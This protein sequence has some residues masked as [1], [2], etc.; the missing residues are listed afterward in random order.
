MKK[1]LIAV[2]LVMGCATTTAIAETF[3]E[4]PLTIIVPYAAGGSSD[5]V[6]RAAGKHIAEATG[7][8]VV[9]ENRP[10]GAT[11]IGAQ[12]L[13]SKP[14]DG[15]TT[16]LVAASFVINPHLL[17]LPYDPDTSFR[18][19]TLVASNPHVLVVN[20]SVPANSLSEFVE[21][22]KS[23]NGGASFSSF[24]NGSSGH[25]G[26]EMLNQMAD[27]NM[28]HVPYKGAAPATMAV[29]SGE[30]DATLADI[31]V[32][33]PHLKSG[34]GKIKA[35][36]ITGD[37]RAATLPD[38]PTFKE[39]GMP[40][41]NSR[42]WLGLW[43]RAE[44]PDDKVRRLNQLF[45]DALKSEEMQALLAQQGFEAGS[46]T[47]EAFAEFAKEESKRYKAAIEKANIRIE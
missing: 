39:S 10:G 11:V 37:K 30:V 40:E 38:V 26:F 8:S 9:V 4:R 3:P 32:V 42:T 20:S 15:Y 23:K 28:L 19:V 7:Q 43:T 25:I 16:M 29:L 35:I 27:I 18:P 13:L 44:V 41:Y 45:N 47:P 34:E 46:T 21:W 12:A 17:K 2:G 24:G 36:A 5:T 1:L 6:A 14:A 22:A 31:G 33:A